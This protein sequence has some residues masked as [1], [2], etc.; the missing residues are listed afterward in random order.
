MSLTLSLFWLLTPD[1]RL[2]FFTR[3]QALLNVRDQL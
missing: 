2:L 3:L 1:L